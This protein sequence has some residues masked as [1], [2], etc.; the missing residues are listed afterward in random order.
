MSNKE[1]TN[2]GVVKIPVAGRV[3][4]KKVLAQ[5]LSSMRA[6]PLLQSTTGM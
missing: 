1:N 4:I 6:Y 2:L 3:A 5:R